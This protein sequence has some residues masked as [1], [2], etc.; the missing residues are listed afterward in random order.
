MRTQAYTHTNACITNTQTYLHCNVQPWDVESLEHD[1]CRVFPVLGGVEGG[2]RQQEIVVLRLSTQVLE[3][4]LLPE[5]LH[6]VPVFDDAM[7]DGVLARVAWLVSFITDEE[8]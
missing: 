6:E 1:L 2:L 5:P 3:D 7:A 8:V 4:A